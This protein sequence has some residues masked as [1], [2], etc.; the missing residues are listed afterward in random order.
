MTLSMLIYN[1]NLTTMLKIGILLLWMQVL[2]AFA[3]SPS[4]SSED[5]E[6]YRQHKNTLLAHNETTPFKLGGLV[7]PGSEFDNE[8][9]KVIAGE[10]DDVDWSHY[11]PVNGELVYSES[12][13]DHQISRRANTQ[14]G[15]I[16]LYV[17]SHTC[18]G[19]R[20]YCWHQLDDG[21]CFS[22]YDDSHRTNYGF[23]SFWKSFAGANFWACNSDGS[24]DCA[25]SDQK[26]GPDSS[27]LCLNR[28]NGHRWSGMFEWHA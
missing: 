17:D 5:A 14:Y 19:G 22:V 28:S 15:T 21:A 27:K 6:L 18:G 4:N 13:I 1:S 16:C 25:Y 11:E 23:V 26:W 20:Y 12:P 10:Q 7:I 2:C 24:Y 9:K 8:M 3:A